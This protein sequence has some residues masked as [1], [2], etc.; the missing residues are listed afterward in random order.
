MAYLG[1]FGNVLA[2][3]G[4]I[5]Q[6]RAGLGMVWATIYGGLRRGYEAIEEG[7]RGARVLGS[8]SLSLKLVA[9]FWSLTNGNSRYPGLLQ[10][11]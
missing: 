1:K 10:K 6:V 7:L 5:G 8:L 4:T 2:R 9:V 3:M 11:I